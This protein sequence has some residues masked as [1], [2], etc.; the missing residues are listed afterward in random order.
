L[1]S[2]SPKPSLTT[3]LAT[4]DEATTSRLPTHISFS[5]ESNS[6]NENDDNDVAAATAAAD[7]DDDDDDDETDLI[8]DHEKDFQYVPVSSQSKLVQFQYLTFA[9]QQQL[10]SNSDDEN[11]HEKRDE[12]FDVCMD[13]DNMNEQLAEAEAEVD[14]ENHNNDDH[15]QHEVRNMLQFIRYPIV[16]FSFLKQ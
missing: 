3:E 7:D 5:Y 14:N 16:F 2:I 8:H 9:R 13:D 11:H 4:L 10:F 15:G 6:D 12:T 1:R